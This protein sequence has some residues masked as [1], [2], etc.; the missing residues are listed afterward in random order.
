MAEDS[1]PSEEHER[2]RLL[3]HFR[4]P[5][6]VL[7]DVCFKSN[8][9][10]GHESVYDKAGKMNGYS[11]PKTNHPNQEAQLTL[12]LSHVVPIYYQNR[13]SKR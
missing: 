6:F 13:R 2:R 1:F 8:G 10:F 12:V 9:Y 11:I 5:T 7:T 4:I 3:H